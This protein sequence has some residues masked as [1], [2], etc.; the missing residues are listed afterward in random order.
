M[1]LRALLI[2]L[3]ICGGT[4]HAAEQTSIERYWSEF[5]QAVLEHKTEKVAAMT[6]FPLW[7]R[8]PGDG[9][10][11]TYYK[12]KDFSPI[13]ERLLRQKVLS[14]NG[15]R[16]VSKT[17]LQV[18]R[19][20]TEITQKDHLTENVISVEQFQFERINGRWLFTRA[21]LEEQ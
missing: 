4:A 18:I 1:I 3:L 17:M 16:V 5:R 12:N 15:G 13:L 9:D 2:I 11:V 14:L 8:G 19:E 10:P 6:R 21:Y 20:K 7:V